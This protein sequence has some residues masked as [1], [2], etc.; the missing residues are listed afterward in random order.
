MLRC[1]C[2]HGKRA[3]ETGRGE[4]EVESCSHLCDTVCVQFWRVWYDGITGTTPIHSM[5]GLRLP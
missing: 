5:D 1:L 2:P 4:I 3:D